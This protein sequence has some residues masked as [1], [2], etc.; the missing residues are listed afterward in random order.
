[1]FRNCL[2]A[3][4]SVLITG[5]SSTDGPVPPEENSGDYLRL[6]LVM[7]EASRA[8]S[9]PDETALDA[10]NGVNPPQ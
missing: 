5:C 1:M 6:S 9:H 3:A 4:L 2:I 8:E 7:S 10:E